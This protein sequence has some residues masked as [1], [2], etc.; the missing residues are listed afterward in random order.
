MENRF[1]ERR[2]IVHP[3]ARAVALSRHLPPERLAYLVEPDVIDEYAAIMVR[4][5]TRDRQ[6]R[7]L[8]F[9]SLFYGGSGA[10]VLLGL[11][12]SL[13]FLAV[14]ALW[15]LAFAILGFVVLKPE[16]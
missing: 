10:L 16:A 7:L 6:R 15:L 14:A 12:L 4:H 2:D 1:N 5:R 8:L 9:W 3:H 13:T 11:T